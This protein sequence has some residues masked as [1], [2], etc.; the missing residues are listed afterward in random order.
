MYE[1]GNDELGCRRPYHSPICK[2]GASVDIHDDHAFLQVV[3]KHGLQYGDPHR[4]YPLPSP[5]MNFFKHVT[6][7][8][9]WV[10]G[11]FPWEVCFKLVLG[12]L[13]RTMSKS[14]DAIDVV[15]RNHVWR[16]ES[17]VR[18]EDVVHYLP[19]PN[20]MLVH[21]LLLVQVG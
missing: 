7:E 15:G 4:W 20:S 6:S 5:L 2:M 14:E 18:C 17:V 21:L 16:W 12:L 3:C 9:D 19:R 1:F 11:H 8:I 10:H 13:I